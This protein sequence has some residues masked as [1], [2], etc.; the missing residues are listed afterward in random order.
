MITAPFFALCLAITTFGDWDE[1]PWVTLEPYSLDRYEVSLP[2][3]PEWKV[4]SGDNWYNVSKRINT[5]AGDFY[6]WVGVEIANYPENRFDW[7]APEIARDF[8]VVQLRNLRDDVGVGGGPVTFFEFGE[9]T[10]GDRTGYRLSWARE[11]L[12]ASLHRMV[13]EYQELHIFFPD[14]LGTDEVAA[15]N[16]G[17]GTLAAPS[18]AL[19]VFFGAE[20]L[21]D[22]AFAYPSVDL[23]YPILNT[24]K[25]APPHD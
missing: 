13:P 11:A 2:C 19:L 10:F 1:V 8:H 16:L 4:R 15:G 21:Q 12:V 20:C 18:D 3:G 9:Q 14:E 25:I 17:T 22:C 7:L 24:I 5:D 6:V 23:L